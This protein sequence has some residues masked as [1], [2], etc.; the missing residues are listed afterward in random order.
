MKGYYAYITHLI[1]SCVFHDKVEPQSMPWVAGVR[2]YEQI[3]F[4][5]TYQIDPP[6]ISYDKR[7]NYSSKNKCNIKTD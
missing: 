4:V 1:L 6:Q 2:P 7:T 3:I 5:F